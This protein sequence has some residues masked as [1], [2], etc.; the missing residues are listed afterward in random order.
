MKT[1]FKIFEIEWNIS[2]LERIIK[3]YQEELRLE[4]R[5]IMV[6]REHSDVTIVGVIFEK[7]SEYE[8]PQNL[9]PDKYSYAKVEPGAH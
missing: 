8:E 9:N 4:V 3:R 6:L 7:S 5:N 2:K 1:I